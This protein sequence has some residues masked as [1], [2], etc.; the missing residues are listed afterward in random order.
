MSEDVLFASANQISDIIANQISQPIR[1]HSQS[2]ITV[3]STENGRR[4]IIKATVVQKDEV[5]NCSNLVESNFV[6]Q[7]N[8]SKIR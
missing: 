6:Y 4:T 5:L 8:N 1:Y 7:M 2:D 3:K